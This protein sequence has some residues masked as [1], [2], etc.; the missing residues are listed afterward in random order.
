MT[1]CRSHAL[2]HAHELIWELGLIKVIQIL[3]KYTTRLIDDLE[4]CGS[5]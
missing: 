1:D 4:D 5:D 2:Q 3:F